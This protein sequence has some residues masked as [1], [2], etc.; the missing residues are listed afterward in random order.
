MY[1]DGFVE[2]NKGPRGRLVKDKEDRKEKK[3]ENYE[4]PVDDG[5]DND[6]EEDDHHEGGKGGKARCDNVPSATTSSVPLTS[7]LSI[8][9]LGEMALPVAIGLFATV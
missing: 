4:H 9:Y 6:G 8:I 5:G 7:L 1:N 3:T 2:T